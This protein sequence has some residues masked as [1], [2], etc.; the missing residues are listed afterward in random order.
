MP[1]FLLP[2]AVGAVSEAM[3]S[4]PLIVVDFRHFF[5]WF[6]TDLIDFFADFNT[7]R[8]KR[9]VEGRHVEEGRFQV[10]TPPLL[11]RLLGFPIWSLEVQ[12][13]FCLIFDE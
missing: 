2:L 9:E 1:G 12:V 5:R 4:G 6:L 10:R 7:K 13:H 11:Y 3:P 8:G